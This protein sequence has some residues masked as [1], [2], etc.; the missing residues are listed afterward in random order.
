V[1]VALIGIGLA[2]VA[3]LGLAVSGYLPDSGSSI[4]PQAEPMPTVDP[5]S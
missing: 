5:D 2:T 1:S 3:L 4:E